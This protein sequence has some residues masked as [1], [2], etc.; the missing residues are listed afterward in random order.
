MRNW[1]TMA[2]PVSADV[3][4]LSTMDASALLIVSTPV[5][6]KL[7]EPATTTGFALAQF[8]E[9]AGPVVLGVILGLETE[10]TL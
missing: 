2:A 1:L 7:L 10:L 4:A 5:T 9:P 6:E 3:P 8:Q